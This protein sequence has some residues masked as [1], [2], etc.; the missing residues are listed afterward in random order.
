VGGATG[1]VGSLALSVACS[2][3][4]AVSFACRA[5]SVR[6]GAGVGASLSEQA[7]LAIKNTSKTREILI[8]FFFNDNSAEQGM[9]SS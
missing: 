6:F 3:A 7:R 4:T 8:I 2:S 5:T 1:K 9:I